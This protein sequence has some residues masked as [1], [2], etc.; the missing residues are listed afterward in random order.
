MKYVKGKPI[1]MLK[2]KKI[3]LC[4]SGGIAAYKCV[5]LASKLIKTGAKVKTVMT[6][7]A[8]EFITPLT[9]RSITKETVSYKLFNND[10]P[11]EHISLA[12]WAD[13]IVIAPATANI[14][15]KIAHGIA[16]DLL[17]TVVM[18]SKCPKLIAPAM[19]V[20]M[21]NNPITQKNIDF[22]KEFGYIFI[23]PDTGRLACGYEAKG[24]MPETEEI[25]FAIKAIIQKPSLSLDYKNKKVLVTAGASVEKIDPMR[26]ISNVSTGKMGIAIAKAAKLRGADVCLIHSRIQEKA[27]Y[28]TK[29][30]ETLSA[31]LMYKKVIEIYSEY[32]VIIM[33]AAV[34]DFTPKDVSQEKIKK[35]NNNNLSIE[36]VRTTDIL[37]ELGK[38]KS[39]TQKLIGFA[40][41]SNNINEYATQKFEKKNLDL[42]IANNLDTAGKDNTT[43]N[44]IG[45]NFNDQHSAEKTEI[46][47]IILDYILKC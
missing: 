18:A 2:D 33:C 21:Y 6:E 27:P 20:N 10:A 4:I 28:C 17:S 34:A 5:D 7:A 1:A 31:D 32:N 9:F 11:I 29:N 40:A 38:S 36:L 15:G 3:L 12:D 41:E 13:L 44:I 35:T 43:V 8:M 16:D 24:R 47:N 39:K 14:I 46:A 23:E 22:L 26:F 42:I 37:S 45:K 19:N 30:I 25:F